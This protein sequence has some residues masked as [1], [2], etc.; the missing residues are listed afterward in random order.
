VGVAGSIIVG[1]VVCSARSSSAGTG[2]VFF[3]LQAAVVATTA[4]MAIKAKNFF[5][6]APLS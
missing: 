3:E 5:I 1:S 4:P 6:T 2:S